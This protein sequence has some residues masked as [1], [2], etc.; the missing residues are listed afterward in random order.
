[1][2]TTSL[3]VVQ[4]VLLAINRRHSLDNRQQRYLTMINNIQKTNEAWKL[5]EFKEEAEKIVTE[6]NQHLLNGDFE[7]CS[8]LLSRLEEIYI[9]NKLYY[10]HEES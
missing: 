10:N 6:I 7:N 4:N 3:C 2:N 5:L 8:D 1:M 9:M